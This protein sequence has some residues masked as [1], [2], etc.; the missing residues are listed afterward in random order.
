MHRI[1]KISAR[2]AVGV[3]CW[4]GAHYVRG[5][6]SFSVTAMIWIY[7]HLDGSV[8]S[9][10]VK[11]LDETGFTAAPNRSGRPITVRTPENVAAARASTQTLPQ[12]STRKHA[13][14]MDMS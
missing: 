2:P 14:A 13:V 3:E 4:K 8:I 9:R 1:W 12:H 6:L 10:G 7:E 11:L 5:T